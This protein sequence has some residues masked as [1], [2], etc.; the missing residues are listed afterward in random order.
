MQKNYLSHVGRILV[1]SL[2]ILIGSSVQHQAFAEGKVTFMAVWGGQE[3]DVF[4][5]IMQAFEKKTG[6]TV[7]YEGTRDLNAV[8][9][10]RVEAGNPPDIAG[11][12][13]PGQMA[14]FA[15]AGKLVDLATVFKMEQIQEEYGAGWIDLGTVDGKYVGLFTKAAVKGLIWYSP[16]QQE[17]LGFAIP[18][19]WDELMAISQKIADQGITPWAIGL[20]S[21]AASGWAG[22]DWFEDIF[23]RMYGPEKYK[24]LYEGKLAWTSDEVRKVWETWGQIVANE[25]MIYGGKQ[26]VL[27]TNF[28]QAVAPLFQEKPQ[29]IF[30]HQASFIQGF[31]KEQ[32]PQLQAVTDFMCFGFPTINPEYQHAVE[33]AGDVIG[34][35][36]DTPEARAFINYLA[37]AE[38]QAFWVKGTGALSPNK[39]VA[40]EDYPDAISKS[41]AEILNNSQIVA[42]DASDMMPSE[43]NNAFW[44]AVLNYVEDPTKLESILTQLEK[45]RQEAY[46]AK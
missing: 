4:Q 30:H 25:N 27:A 26:Y 16:K 40:V 19:T 17:A 28:G 20:E 18:T 32:F 31:I 6:I 33:V 42:F 45:I 36:N 34:M 10:T 43:M 5:Q 7:E 39:K 38:A 37:T 21:G 24:A 2:M 22:T 1:C 46:A 15:R 44:T 8:L 29:A 9:T 35:F 14:Q 13:G 12:P 11:L 23:L 41:S 3:L